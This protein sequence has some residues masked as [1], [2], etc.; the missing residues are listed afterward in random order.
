[1]VFEKMLSSCVYVYSCISI[2]IILDFDRHMMVIMSSENRV[3]MLY[4]LP[5]YFF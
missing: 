3:I 4:K 2:S 1:M 5:K